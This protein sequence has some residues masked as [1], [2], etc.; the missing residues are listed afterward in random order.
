M[1]NQCKKR[2]I[3]MH[4]LWAV[5]FL[6]TKRLFGPILSVHPTVSFNYGIRGD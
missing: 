4:S 6:L 3:D 2:M 1:H 5:R